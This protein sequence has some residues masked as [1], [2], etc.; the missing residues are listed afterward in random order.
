MVIRRKGNHYKKHCQD[1]YGNSSEGLS[2]QL[3]RL[4]GKE[5]TEN[6]PESVVIDFD[7]SG[8]A[9]TPQF[10]HDGQP[11][12]PP[13]VV[14]TLSKDKTSPNHRGVNYDT[15]FFVPVGGNAKNEYHTFTAPSTSIKRTEEE[16]VEPTQV[17]LE[18]QQFQSP[19]GAVQELRG[20]ER[21]DVV[22]CNI[23]ALGQVEIW[24]VD[25]DDYASLQ[26]EYDSSGEWHP[27]RCKIERFSKSAW[28]QG[29]TECDGAA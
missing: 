25:P 3:A 11:V 9:D 15:T 22:S 16:G 23:N 21:S 12:Y 6:D 20:T 5:M 19:W 27:L 17:A 29:V 18:L 28:K 4:I 8:G 26:A 2:I 13:M 7:H 14:A 24:T 1:V 10:F